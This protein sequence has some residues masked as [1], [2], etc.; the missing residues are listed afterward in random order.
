MAR[1]RVEGGP[2]M[3]RGRVYK[4]G[5][6]LDSDNDLEAEFPNKFT[7][8]DDPRRYAR[9]AQ[10]RG[11]TGPEGFPP[12]P[13]A[14]PPGA[15]P[16][17]PQGGEGERPGGEGQPQGADGPQSWNDLGEDVTDQF[18]EAPAVGVKVIKQGKKYMTY[19]EDDPTQ[20][21]NGDGFTRKD[22][23]EEFLSDYKG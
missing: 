13:R 7:R 8:L 5:E 1:F 19:R 14:D 18:V 12:A 21:L 11:S 2:H 17:A 3:D 9:E 10:G 20:A 22:Q 4:A 23:V 6:E 15:P 16:Q